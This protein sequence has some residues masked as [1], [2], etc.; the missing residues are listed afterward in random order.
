MLKELLQ[1]RS[2]YSSH[3]G[4]RF[5]DAI[6]NARLVANAEHYYR[7]MYYGSRDS[8]NLR[9]S[10][11]Y[12]TLRN[13][14]EHHGP[15]SKG[16]VWAHNSHVGDSEATEMSARDEYNIGHLCR[17]DFG[18]RCYSIGFGTDR[19]TV[20]AAANWDEPMQIMTVR[21]A[22]PGSYEHACRGYGARQFFLPLRSVRGCPPS[23]DA[24]QPRLERA[25]GVIYRP[26]TELQ[27]HYFEA[28]L[29]RQFD[30]YV[31]IDSTKA[32][33]PLST[34]ETEGLPETYPFGL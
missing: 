23:S 5:L 15:S 10:H 16:V 12:E 3:D 8:W 30:E 29:P 28:V 9:D 11:M 2:A 17:K 14:L 26:A 6:Q 21:P 25:I 32:V 4:E 27:S 33:T 13:L 24:M 31:W 20:A 34:E 1:K 19:G 22:L 7:I 18:R